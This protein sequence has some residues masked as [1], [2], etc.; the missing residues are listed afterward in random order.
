MPGVN[1][2][3]K[4]STQDLVLGRGAL[5]FAA[6]DPTTKKPLGF[7]HL[8]NCTAFA[9]NV[10]SELLEHFSSRTG[11]RSVDREIILSQKFGI[12]L[13]LDEIN[14]QNLA[15]FTS[16]TATK[17]VTNPAAT[18]VG[19]ATPGTTEI[20]ISDA[21]YKGFNYDLVNSVG[22]RLF[23]LNATGLTV[24]S[25]AS[26][27][28]SAATLVENTDYEVDRK[29]GTIHLLSTGSTH[30]DGNDLWFS[31]DT[32]GTGTEQPFDRVDFLNQTSISGF[33]RFKMIN[34]A[35]SDKQMLID[36]H[37]VN[38]KADGDLTLI[39]DEYVSMT[40][41][42]SAE[43]NEVGYPTSPVGSAYYHA[44]A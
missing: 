39:S 18:D 17:A 1:T 19:T 43:R 30:T 27:L 21:A 42:G 7:R 13:T 3:G 2:T 10:T 33:L 20:K 8:G 12:T 40:L 6:L 38:L 34:A 24:K 14:F 15:L 29:W 44:D 35:N 37:S 36:L 41:V 16:G 11:V 28:A 26:T 23:D 25:H 22:A 31:Y 5:F 9:V 32:D 4:P